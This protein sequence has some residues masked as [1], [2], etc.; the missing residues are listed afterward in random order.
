[1]REIV[2]VLKMELF[3]KFLFAFKHYMWNFRIRIMSFSIICRNDYIIL[4]WL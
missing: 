1:M 4:I 2:Q 3:F